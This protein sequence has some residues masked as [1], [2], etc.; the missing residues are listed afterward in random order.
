[1]PVKEMVNQMKVVELKK[2]LRERFE[3][4]WEKGWFNRVLNAI[5][6]G[7][8]TVQNAVEKEQQVTSEY[9]SKLSLEDE[10]IPDPLSLSDNWL[11]EEEG[12][13]KWPMISYPNIFNYLM[14]QPA[15]LGG[16]NWMHTRLQK[17]IIIL[18][19]VG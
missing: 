13:T 15:E 1:M 3:S 10:V 11:P 5:E 8:R 18:K 14:F 9:A 16:R 7:V 4:G 2:F 19:M 12:I 6:N 17:P